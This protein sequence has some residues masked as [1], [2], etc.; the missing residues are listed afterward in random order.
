MRAVR[1]HLSLLFLAFFFEFGLSGLGVAAAKDATGQGRPSV[2]VGPGL[3]FAIA[4]FDGDRRADLVSVE[5]HQLGSAS[6]DYSIR[7]QLT[8]DGR[9]AIRVVAPSGGLQIEARDVNGDRAVDL[10]LITVWFKRPVAILLNDGRGRFSYAEPSRFPGAFRD[11]PRHWN[12]YSSPKSEAVGIPP[13]SGSC[14]EAANPPDV[15]GPTQ[16]VCGSYSGFLLGS[17]LFAYAGRA[18][19]SAVTYL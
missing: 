15:R 2:G 3:S 5:G 17:S 12:S 13:R 19:P 9:Q 8:A 14:S 7:L 6:R 11:S 1:S 4:D 10:V 16:F 18:P